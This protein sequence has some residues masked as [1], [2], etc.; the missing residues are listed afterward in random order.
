MRLMFET[1]ESDCLRCDRER[2]TFAGGFAHDVR[3]WGWR[4]ALYNVWFRFFGEA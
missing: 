3:C 4:T 1:V 2:F